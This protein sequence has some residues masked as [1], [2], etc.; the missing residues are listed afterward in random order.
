MKKVFLSFITLAFAACATSPVY[1]DSTGTINIDT[2]AKTQSQ[3]TIAT[4]IRTFEA[5]K[6]S[7]KTTK[8]SQVTRVGH[9]IKN[10]VPLTGAQWEFVTFQNSVPN[11]FALPGGKVGV[12]TGILP[13]AKNDAGLATILAHEIAHVSRNHHEAR[14]KRS[15][16]VGLGGAI[17][18]S[19][20]GGGYS[21][22]IGAGGQ[23]AINLP[24]SRSA[25]I[26][27]DQVG[28]IYMARAGYDPR[29]AINFWTRFSEYKKSTGQ[30]GTAFF[31]THPLDATRIARLKQV[32][33]IAIKEYEKSR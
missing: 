12:H 14:A 25:E 21:D 23:L 29:E 31:S 4:G 6:R 24:N 30:S 32:L 15:A 10:V 5:Y 28:L 19:A 7:K 18:N 11:A 22:V 1:T 2:T 3:A 17:L 26:E 27:A 9:R 13:I 8:N 20:L 33:P 16:L